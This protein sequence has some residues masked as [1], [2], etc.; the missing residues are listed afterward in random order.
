MLV[1]PDQRV[2]HAFETCVDPECRD[3]YTHP[4]LVTEGN[5][6]KGAFGD[7]RDVGGASDP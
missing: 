4:K 5:A 7:D 1:P 6:G 3:G 2:V